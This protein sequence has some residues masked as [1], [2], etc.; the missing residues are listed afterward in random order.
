MNK[1]VTIVIPTY[2]N[3]DVI[4]ETL[5]SI[6]S[7]TYQ[8]WEAICVDD[9]SSDNTVSTILEYI[10]N[11]SR[12]SL[13]KR[14]V[15]SKGGSVCRNIG[16]NNAKG[17]YIIFLDADDLLSSSCLATR[18]QDMNSNSSD[19]IVYPNA[20]I[21]EGNVGKITSDSR[22]RKP[23]LAY[24]SN[25]AVWQT[26][27]PIY[28]TNFVKSVKGFDE[29]FKRLQDVEFG[30]RCIAASNGN[31]IIKLKKQEPDCFY[32]LGDVVTISKKYEIGFSMFPLFTELVHKQR[33]NTVIS[34]SDFSKVLLC[35]I[36][37]IIIVSSITPQKRPY[38]E[39]FSFDYKKDLCLPER[40][41]LS[42]LD[43]FKDNWTCYKKIAHGIKY[44]YTRLFF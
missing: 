8:N 5:G 26:T 27:C 44:L 1:L 19:F 18:V 4:L 14:N 43:I 13:Y 7:Q 34:K 30:L 39:V 41:I 12:F 32:R 25:H 21:R 15:E 11:D 20:T 31:Y 42:L 17:D 28:R 35:L 10:K 37:S 22:V 9:G 33:V 3:Q 2:N 36:C 6:K 16:I 24:A 38:H 29:N 23:L 40:V